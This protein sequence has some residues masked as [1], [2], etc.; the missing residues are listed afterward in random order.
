MV[1]K[2]NEQRETQNEYKIPQKNYFDVSK[3]TL[4]IESLCLRKLTTSRD[5]LRISVCISAVGE[6]LD[7]S[8]QRR[9][10]PSENDAFCQK[11]TV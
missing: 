4:P 9:G 2:K 1:Y 8:D 11:Y 5:F 7:K 10:F 6:I 3:G